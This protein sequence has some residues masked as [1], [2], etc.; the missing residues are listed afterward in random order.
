MKNV[1]NVIGIMSGTSMDGVDL[2]YCRLTRKKKEWKTEIVSANT[3][4]YNSEWLDAL[5]NAHNLAGQELVHLHT[6]YGKFIGQLVNS[7]IKKEK[8]K[9]IDLI[10]SHGHTIFHQPA[11]QFTF[12]LGDGN[13]IH[14]KTKIPVAFDFRSLDV[15]LGGEGAPLVP[16]GDALLFKNYDL[17]LNLGGIGNISVKEKNKITAFDFCYCNMALNYLASKAGKNFDHKGK[18]SRQGHVNENLLSQIEKIY[19][20]SAGERP[21]LG[22]ESFEKDFKTL[23]EDESI[24]LNDRLRTICESVANELSNIIPAK[25]KKQRLLVTGGGAFNNFLIQQIEEKLKERVTVIVPEKKI[26]AFKEALVFAFLGVLR[27]RGEINVLKDVTGAKKDS[28]SGI[29]VGV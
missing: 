1:Y 3:F 27:L 28:C 23:L 29:L 25:K 10:A 24:P 20:S 5:S 15:A 6:R 13:A 14:A 22:R 8:I 7:F 17:C 19:Y 9:K 26:V 16:I 12:Q 18:M 21:S 11:R 4:G 2:T